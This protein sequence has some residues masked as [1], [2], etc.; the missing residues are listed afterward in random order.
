MTR[1]HRWQS[2]K[3][4]LMKATKRRG[5]ADSAEPSMHGMTRMPWTASGRRNEKQVKCP[6]T[7][8]LLNGSGLFAF[9]IRAAGWYFVSERA[10]AL[11]WLQWPALRLGIF[12][13]G[14]PRPAVPET[15]A[16]MR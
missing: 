14:A 9:A 10:A 5:Y 7:F 3:F 13:T 4:G 8:S 12:R 6:M 16:E 15:L 1:L 2:T 11:A